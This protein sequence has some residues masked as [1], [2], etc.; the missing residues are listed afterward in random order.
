M[1]TL[2]GFLKDN[3]GLYIT[4]DEDAVLTYSLDWTDWLPANTAITGN[5]FTVETITGDTDALVKVSQSNTDT[6]ATIKVSGGTSGKIYK[7]YN[8]ITITGSLIERRYFRVKVTA[9]SL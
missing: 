6:V 9:R 8:T 4:K 2:T 3:E 5:S 7:V 1:A